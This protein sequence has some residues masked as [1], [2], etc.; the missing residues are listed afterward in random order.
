MLEARDHLLLDGPVEV[1]ETGAVSGDP[2]DQVFMF[3]RPGDGGAER[4][5]REPVHLNLKSAQREVRLQRGLKPPVS[6]W[7][8]RPA[9]GPTFL[10]N[11]SP[12]RRPSGLAP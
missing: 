7:R 9:M 5:G 4:L 10:A 6:P 3:P 8:F 11:G 12:A 2:D 1:D